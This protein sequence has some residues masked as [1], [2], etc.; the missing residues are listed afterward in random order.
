MN[1]HPGCKSPACQS[2]LKRSSRDYGG[3][4]AEVTN[5][6]EEKIKK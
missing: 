1:N 3:K 2:N 5:E 4:M 6:G